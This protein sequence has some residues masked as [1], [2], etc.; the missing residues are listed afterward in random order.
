MIEKIANAIT[1]LKHVDKINEIIDKFNVFYKRQVG[2]ILPIVASDNYVPDG[3][4][5]CDGT[6]YTRE[7]FPDLWDNF[8][9]STT[10][11]LNTAV[12][13]ATGT[14]DSGIVNKGN[15]TIHS[16]NKGDIIVC[17]LVGSDIT[18]KNGIGLLAG[19]YIE[20]GNFYKSDG[21]LLTPVTANSKLYIK[22]SHTEN[23]DE[24]YPYKKNY[25]WSLDS[26]SFDVYNNSVNSTSQNVSVSN[27]YEGYPIDLSNSYFEQ[28]GQKEYLYKTVA[29]LNTCTYTEYQEELSIYG[30]CNKFAVDNEKFR[31]PLISQQKRYLIAKKEPTDIDPSWYNLYS[32]GWCEQGGKVYT[33]VNGWNTVEL[34]KEYNGEYYIITNRARAYTSSSSSTH[35][36]VMDCAAPI[37]HETIT[38]NT[39]QF[40]AQNDDGTYFTTWETQ[41][42]TDFKVEN[43]LRYF[44]VVA[45]GQTNQSMMD[46]SQWASSLQGKANTDLS[47]VDKVSLLGLRKL[48]EVSDP[49]L[50]PS[51]Y[52][53]F[54]EIQPNGS[55][56]KWCEQG[57][58]NT[59]SG[60]DGSQTFT[61]LKEF[62]DLSYEIFKNH[63]SSSSSNPSGRAMSFYNKTTSSAT[64]YTFNANASWYACGYIN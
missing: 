53:V 19:G 38:S 31:V 16:E 46:W 5:P 9:T 29:L 12:T 22:I 55:I 52:K 32:D 25:Y 37:N 56:K 44:V 41:G 43:P 11:I 8:L 47:N 6:E 49:S 23:A 60:L 17:F 59:G 33:V 20:N 21:T 28:N 24:E 51:W 27:Y 14:Y 1:P 42:Y 45:N 2:E 63:S 26:V 13:V 30:Q 58:T 15:I 18:T 4:L 64:T 61:F 10:G 54:E 34:L 57:F 62:T 48:V 3:T 50:M 36:F 7:Q 40:Y 39:F 35:A